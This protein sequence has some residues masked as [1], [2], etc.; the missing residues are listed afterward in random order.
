M[1]WP[2]IV[3][4]SSYDRILFFVYRKKFIVGFAV[5]HRIVELIDSDVHSDVATL[6]CDRHSLVSL[7][8]LVFRF[9]GLFFAFSALAFSFVSA[10]TFAFSALSCSLTLA[11]SF[12]SRVFAV[13]SLITWS[14]TSVSFAL[15][16]TTYLGGSCV[17]SFRIAVRLTIKS[18]AIMGCLS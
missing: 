6:R 16:K 17:F 13:Y 3:I 8:V 14:R 18:Q 2:S 15:K 12:L 10:L 5:F 4:S 7:S 9:L 11:F 1:L